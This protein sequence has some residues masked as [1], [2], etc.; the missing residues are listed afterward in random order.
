MR[1]FEM[2]KSGPIKFHYRHCEIMLYG[3]LGQ[4]ATQLALTAYLFATHHMTAK[5][6]SWLSS[7]ANGTWRN[8]KSAELI[9]ASDIYPSLRPASMPDLFI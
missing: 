7:D 6:M 3:N 9:R 2:L 5:Q 1:G 8:N 4:A